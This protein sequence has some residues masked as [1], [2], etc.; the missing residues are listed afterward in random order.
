M[1]WIKNEKSLQKKSAD[2]LLFFQVKYFFLVFFFFYFSIDFVLLIFFVCFFLF[3]FFLSSLVYC[4]LL[5]FLFSAMQKI[6]KIDKLNQQT[7]SPKSQIQFFSQIFFLSIFFSFLYFCFMS[8]L[9]IPRTRIVFFPSTHLR[10]CTSKKLSLDI[11]R[12]WLSLVSNMK[13]Q[14]HN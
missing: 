4:S 2:Y 13:F 12:L 7:K 14:V 11:A 1:K 10:H 5:K 8:I 6:R 9:T 3:F